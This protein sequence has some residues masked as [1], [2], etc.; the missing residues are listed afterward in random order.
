MNKFFKHI[1]I[2]FFIV[3][4]G[5]QPIFEKINLEIENLYDKNNEIDSAI[6]NNLKN[7]KELENKDKNR[8]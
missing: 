7:Y 2:F 8:F 5:Y 4:C 6:N 1:F 3:N